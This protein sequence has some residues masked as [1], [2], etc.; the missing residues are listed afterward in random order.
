MP[1]RKAIL[2]VEDDPIIRMGALSL[3]AEAGFEAVE[4]TNAA[5]AIRILEARAGHSFGVYRRRNARDD[6]RDQTVTLHPGSLAAGQTDRG[7]GQRHSRRKPSSRGRQI[8]R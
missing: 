5:D 3:V 1:N 2:V 6:G 7:F 4:A 8:F